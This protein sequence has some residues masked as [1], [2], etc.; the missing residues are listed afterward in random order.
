MS[1]AV[2]SAL[3]NGLAVV[4]G[5]GVGSAINMG[6]ITLNTSKYFY[7]MP[8]G[9]SFED[10]EKFGEYIAGLPPMAYAMVFA[11][12]FGQA[13]VGGIVASTLAPTKES[14][15]V[16]CYVVGGL[17][18]IGAIMNTMALP[19]PAWTWIEIPMYPFIIYYT[20]QFAAGLGFGGKK[21][22]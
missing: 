5:V 14:G 20:S 18:M 22:D 2:A 4:A 10:T 12:H 21:G 13:I 9:V 6:L 19:V 17:T 16:C 15:T 11:A 1:L 8:D 3:R 7:P